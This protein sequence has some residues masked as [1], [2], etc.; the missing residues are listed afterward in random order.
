MREGPTTASKV[1]GVMYIN[2][3]PIAVDEIKTLGNGDIWA[4]HGF[5]WFAVTGGGREYS[6]I[7]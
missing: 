2:C 7:S 3:P 4:R 1:Y 5:F 6:R